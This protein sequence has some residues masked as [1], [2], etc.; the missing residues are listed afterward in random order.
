MRIALQEP[1]M[2]SSYPGLLWPEYRGLVKR[3]HLKAD[4]SIK[5]TFSLSGKSAVVVDNEGKK[6]LGVLNLSEAYR[7]AMKGCSC[8]NRV[9]S[10]VEKATVHRASDGFDSLINRYLEEK[11]AFDGTDLV[12][13]THPDDSFL[14]FIEVSDLLKFIEKRKYQEALYT[15]PLTGLPGKPLIE[16]LLRKKKEQDACHVDIT[17]F[18]AYNDKYGIGRGDEVL[19]FTATVL[20]QELQ[21]D[22]V[23]FHIGGDDFFCIHPGLGG[24]AE[25]VTSKFDSRIKEFYDVQDARDGFIAAEDRRGELTFFPIMTISL[26]ISPG[27]TRETDDFAVI[28]HSLARVK[29][30]AKEETKKRGKSV[31]MFDKRSL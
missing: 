12:V 21:P 7:E 11:G 31:F 28:T 30:L 13:L 24:P 14:G 9:S 1:G 3:D 20:V 25:A 19:K 22:G 8:A 17:D 27:K 15:N 18:K 6:V 2:G 5:D 29:K 4:S 10:F 16:E 26:A 23:V